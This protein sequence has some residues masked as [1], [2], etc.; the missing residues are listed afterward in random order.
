MNNSIIRCITLNTT[1]NYV[2]VSCL[3]RANN[4]KKECPILVIQAVE[5]EKLMKPC[6]NIPANV[7]LLK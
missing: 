5:K 3:F 4:A 7:A 6:A 2:D 1:N